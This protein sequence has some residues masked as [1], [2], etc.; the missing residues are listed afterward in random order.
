LYLN[1]AIKPLV[2][3]RLQAYGKIR[4]SRDEQTVSLIL[5]KLPPFR[6]ITDI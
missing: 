5:N 1:P 2:F 6:G 3:V 4:R